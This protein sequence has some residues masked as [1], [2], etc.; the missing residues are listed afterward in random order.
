MDKENKQYK[1]DNTNTRSRNKGPAAKILR[2]LL[3]MFLLAAILFAG[4]LE[5]LTLTE[6]RPQEREHVAVSPWPGDP[7]YPGVSLKVMTW[8]CGYGALGDNADFFMDGGK[9]VMTADRERVRSNLAGIEQTA[10]QLQPDVCFLQEVDR[11]STRSHHI[12]ELIGIN[13]TLMEDYELDYIPAFAYN[14]DVEF[15]PFPIPPI[16]KVRSGIMTLT[17]ISIESAERIQ[18]PCPFKWPVRLGNLKRCLLITRTPVRETDK[19][20]VLINLHLE[21]FDDGDGKIAQTKAL[22]DILNEEA[23]KGNYVIAGGDF[24]QAFNNTDI[25]AYPQQ[26]G[27][28][29]P[30]TIDTE[31]FG[32]AWQCLMDSR[33]PTCRSL[34]QPYEGAD[35]DTFQYYVI[36]GFIVSSN[37]NVKSCETQ[38][39]GF[40]R[41]DHNPVLMECVLK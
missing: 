7:I 26:E 39:M 31:E 41:T 14:Y 20:L 19:E 11:D 22:R 13:N 8:N 9:S 34:D 25:S 33:V 40:V 38:D 2:F 36:D 10:A 16:G 17:D 27:K 23:A 37:I 35:H 28:W 1:P 15:V 4:L 30:G 29:Q 18:L 5:Y 32:D 12:D 6:Y 24:N 3:S 21:A